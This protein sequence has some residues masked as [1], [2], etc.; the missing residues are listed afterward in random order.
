MLGGSLGLPDFA[1]EFATELFAT[2]VL[3]LLQAFGSREDRDTEP[4]EHTG[5]VGIADIEATTRGR[6][7][8]EIRKCGY[9]IHILH[10]NNDGLVTVGIS[11]VGDIGDVSFVFKDER[12]ALLEFGVRSGALGLAGARRISQTG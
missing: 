6:N 3:V 10:L 11:S 9:V 5:D 1:N 8:G 12:E 4:I 7:A 2:A